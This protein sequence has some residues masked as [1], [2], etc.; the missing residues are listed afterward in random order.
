M[1][2]DRWLGTE[3]AGYRIDA[4]IGRGGMG[5]VYRATHQVLRRSVALK[6]LADGLAADPEYRR[7]FDREARLAAALDHPHIVPIHDAGYAQDVLYLAM[8]YIDGPNLA[9][10]ID[11]EAPMDL[12]LVCELVAGVAD[13]LDSAHRAGLVH[14][15]V[16][17]ANILVTGRAVPSGRPRAY[18]CDFGI[19]RSTTASTAQTT[20][21]Q[22]LGTLQY[23]APEQ[24]QGHPL[25]GRADQYALAC[26]IHHCLTGQP[27][28]PAGEPSAVIFAHL[29]ADPPRPSTRN[30]ALPA[31]VDDVIARA[32]AKQPAHRYPDCSTFL[33]ALAAAGGAAPTAPATVP[34]TP[35]HDHQRAQHPD[36]LI[37]SPRPSQHERAATPDGR[38]TGPAPKGGLTRRQVVGL[39]TALGLLGVGG[40]AAFVYNHHDVVAEIP[41][42]VPRNGILDIDGGLA[43]APD[44]RRAYA[45][46]HREVVVIDTGRH[47]MAATIP[48]PDAIGGR[49]AI[50]PDGRH[51][52]I[53]TR[54]VADEHPAV[55]VLETAG[56]TV[57]ATIPMLGPPQGVAISPDGRR[58]YV[59]VRGVTAGE[60]HVA[61]IDTAGPAVIAAIPVRGGGQQVAISPD[62]QRAYVG[63]ASE[64]QVISTTTNAVEGTIPTDGVAT[65]LAAT[66]DGVHIYCAATGSIDR[67][68]WLVDTGSGWTTA[69]FS[70]PGSGSPGSWEKV[71]SLGMTPDGRSVYIVTA[72][73]SPTSTTETRVLVVDVDRA[74]VTGSFPLGAGFFRSGSSIAISHDGRHLYLHSY[75]SI[76]VLEA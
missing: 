35:S 8:G 3:L 54:S 38:A 24:I 66:A 48:F 43:I 32:M 27:P 51:A 39:A 30:P 76:L 25:D 40:L 60:D 36:T 65:H 57:A 52:Y 75:D 14:R 20:T 46:A 19:A 44:G 49:V 10:V 45:V 67:P 64:L 11:H 53:T 72:S 42:P 12:A 63:G 47:E 37:W 34:P 6:L 59:N 50:T 5:A 17:P 7:R 31:A 15:D 26:A 23:C 9:T 21:G 68:A 4:L 13:A 18:L 71:N 22:F 1:A 69:Q 33:H 56:N 70:Y 73:S 29:S 16:K 74:A 28:Y 58:A 61:V 62:G 2:G 41:L 55:L